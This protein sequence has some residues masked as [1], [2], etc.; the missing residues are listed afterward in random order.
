MSMGMSPD[1]LC[2]CGRVQDLLSVC[3]DCDISAYGFNQEEHPI[4]PGLSRESERV[5]ESGSSLAERRRA[6]LVSPPRLIHVN[7]DRNA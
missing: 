7:D 3:G 5:R 2:D 4:H 6:P 1:Y